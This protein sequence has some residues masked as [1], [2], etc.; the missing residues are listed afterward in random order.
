MFEKESRKIDRLT[1]KLKT[2]GDVSQNE[3]DYIYIIDCLLRCY[4]HGSLGNFS[5][6]DYLRNNFYA[7]TESCS[8]LTDSLE[9]WYDAV[10]N[11]IRFHK[12]GN[13]LTTVSAV[14]DRYTERKIYGN[15]QKKTWQITEGIEKFET[16]S[17]LRANINK[18]MAEWISSHREN[19]LTFDVFAVANALGMP[20]NFIDI[21]FSRPNVVNRLFPR[22]KGFTYIERDAIADLKYNVLSHLGIPLMYVCTFEEKMPFICPAEFEE[23][24]SAAIQSLDEAALSVP[25][26]KRILLNTES[27]PVKEIID[28]L[29]DRY[30]VFNNEEKTTFPKDVSYI[31]SAT[32]KLKKYGDITEEESDNIYMLFKF[33]QSL[34]IKMQ[35]NT[36]FISKAAKEINK[37]HLETLFDAFNEWFKAVHRTLKKN[38]KGNF[39]YTIPSN[40]DFT[41]FKPRTYIKKCLDILPKEPIS[42]YFDAKSPNI[43]ELKESLID[44]EVTRDDNLSRFNFN[45]YGSLSRN[46][47]NLDD[48]KIA[49]EDDESNFIKQLKHDNYM[50]RNRIET[51][52]IGKIKALES[53]GISVLMMDKHIVV[54]SKDFEKAKYIIDI[55]DEKI[56]NIIESAKGRRPITFE[57]VVE[58]IMKL[59]Q[60]QKERE[61]ALTED[62][63]LMMER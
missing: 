51:A 17:C 56:K 61:K 54:P 50:G 34:N 24:V 25:E 45:R 3:A 57:F 14:R 6:F 5:Y 39:I 18:P 8:R 2:Q 9:K 20:E 37:K 15:V 52:R 55:P 41:L 26:S 46:E 22:G 27:P 16:D 28:K 38:K 21:G 48:C 40:L 31:L 60:S 7:S 10:L 35:K 13:F 4:S 42:M 62:D 33:A 32:E 43:P 36:M 30:G 23:I 59:V 11:N 63:W 19:L 29:T 47:I 1:Q 49:W 53:L 12:T 44:V 58:I